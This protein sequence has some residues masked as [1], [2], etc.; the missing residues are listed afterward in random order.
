MGTNFPVYISDQVHVLLKWNPQI[1]LGIK[2]RTEG[3]LWEYVTEILW[4]FRLIP[5]SD[6]GGAT[7]KR[8]V[9]LCVT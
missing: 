7:D 1:E 2:S 8:C 6:L 5:F 3:A 4:K 9:P